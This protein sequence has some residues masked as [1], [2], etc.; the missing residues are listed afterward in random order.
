M[1]S[2]NIVEIN[3]SF[4]NNL[5]EVYE[6]NLFG[7]F[8]TA[9]YHKESRHIDIN[10]ESDRSKKLEFVSQSHGGLMHLVRNC[11]YLFKD[12]KDRQ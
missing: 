2:T 3:K 11:V 4:N 8:C 1:K 9:T 6:L 10:F 12:L 7:E 5:I